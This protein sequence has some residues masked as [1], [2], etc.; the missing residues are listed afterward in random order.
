MRFPILRSSLTFPRRLYVLTA[1]VNVLSLTLTLSLWLSLW[2]RSA[3][4]LPLVHKNRANL[5]AQ[6][7][8]TPPPS[9]AT[10]C[11]FPTPSLCPFF[12]QLFSALDVYNRQTH[13]YLSCAALPSSPLCSISKQDHLRKSLFPLY[14]IPF[15][16]SLHPSK[17]LLVSFALTP[18]TALMNQSFIYSTDP[19]S[20]IA[21]H[22][23]PLHLVVA[24]LYS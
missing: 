3:L 24:S 5:Q 17:F 6:F 21:L 22:T 4:S 2:G 15:T 11:L 23:L 12:R 9:S 1:T 20:T 13:K 7:D 10:F 16:P 8:S 18:Q 19:L 14:S